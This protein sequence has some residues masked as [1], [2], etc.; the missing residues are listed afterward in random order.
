MYETVCIWNLLFLKG[1]SSG[2]LETVGKD[3]DITYLFVMS[4][5][6]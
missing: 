4:Y 1:F 5:A 2:V 6:I 3:K